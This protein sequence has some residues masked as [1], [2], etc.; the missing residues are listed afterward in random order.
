MAVKNASVIGSG[1]NGL[2]GAITLAHAGFN[3]TVFE[4]QTTIGGGARSAELT[5]PGFVHDTCS[6]VHP[7]AVSSPAFASFPLRDFGLEWIEPSAQVAHPLDDGRCVLVY[8]SIGETASQLGRDASAYR[9]LMEPLAEHW[10]ELV[11]DILAP[12]GVPKH[13]L[14]LARFGWRAPWSATAAARFSFRAE[15]ARAVFAG[16]AAHSILPLEYPGSAAFGWLL[17]ASAHGVGWP[18]ARGGSQAISNALARYFESLGGRIIINTE[19]R[20]LDLFEP[21]SLVL[22]DVTPRQLLG[23]A[24]QRLSGRYREKLEAYRYGPGV[25]KMD[26][27]LDRPIPWRAA[28]CSRAATVH[29]GGSL[30]E[31][32]SSECA[33]WKGETSEHP[34]VLLAQ[35]S[36]FDSTR[37]PAG[38]HTAWAYC[39]V[40]NGSPV[41]MSRQIENQIERFAP[42]FRDVVIARHATGPAEM[43]RSNANI[44]GGDIAGGA[45]NMQQLLFRYT[46]NAYRVPITGVYLCSSSTPPGA[47]VHGMC[48]YHAAGMALRDMAR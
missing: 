18:I 12:L 10:H 20:S 35:S 34:F 30:E 19:V 39:H 5:L 11:G 41:D 45:Q 37:A 4:A 26:W 13:P 47:G 14:L 21:G 46:K 40:P 3:V 7:L 23:I 9:R 1:P 28:E 27:A 2:T 15:A 32:A 25:F 31:I 42:G 36:L 24:G 6:A 17:S 43:E 48:G 38:K 29:I 44:L 33:A 22:C 16:M 8:R